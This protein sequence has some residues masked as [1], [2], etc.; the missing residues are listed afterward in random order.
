MLS[1]KGL[2]KEGGNRGKVIGDQENV[3]YFYGFL[4]M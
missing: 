1:R 4:G 2:D 3:R